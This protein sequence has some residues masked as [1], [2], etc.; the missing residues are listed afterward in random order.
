LLPARV[1]LRR[2]DRPPLQQVRRLCIE[3][4]LDVVGSPAEDV[5]AAERM[6]G[7]HPE[8]RV[9]Q[10]QAR[11]QP[12]ST[13]SARVPPPVSRR[14]ANVFTPAQRSITSPVRATR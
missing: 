11:H 9:G 14:K 10:A 7:Q 13:G 4:P 1:L 6:P 3:G 12:G 8:V 5:C 2:R